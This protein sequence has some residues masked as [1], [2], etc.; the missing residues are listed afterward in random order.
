MKANF[1]LLRFART[2]ATFRPTDETICP[3]AHC[4]LAHP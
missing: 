4:E 3:H 1:R 2:L